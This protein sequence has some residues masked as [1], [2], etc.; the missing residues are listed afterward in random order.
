[1]RATP[2]LVDWVN[3]KM[4]EDEDYQGAYLHTFPDEAAL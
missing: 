1:M 2:G 3:N 4:L